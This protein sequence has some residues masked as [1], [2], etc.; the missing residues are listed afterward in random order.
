MIKA[1]M[2]IRM[3]RMY[4]NLMKGIYEKPI[5]NIILNGG[6]TEIIS[7]MRQGYPLSPLLFTVV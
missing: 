5:V 4:L 3:E 2:K 7:K 1:L 6:N